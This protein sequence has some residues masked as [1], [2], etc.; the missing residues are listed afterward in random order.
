MTRN[1]SLW[2]AA[3]ISIIILIILPFSFAHDEGLC[4]RHLLNRVGPAQIQRHSVGYFPRICGKQNATS[5]SRQHNC[6][7]QNINLKPCYC[8]KILLLYTEL[9]WLD[10][11]CNIRLCLYFFIFLALLFL[12]PVTKWIFHDVFWIHYCWL[13]LTWG[14]HKSGFGYRPVRCQTPTYQVSWSPVSQTCYS[15]VN[16][17]R[18]CCTYCR[19]D[20]GTWLLHCFLQTKSAQ[21]TINVAIT[22]HKSSQSMLQSQPTNHNQCCNH[23]AQIITITVA[24]TAHKSVLQSQ[25]TNHHNQCCNHSTQ[26][27]INVAITAHKSVLQSQHTNHNQ[28]C[29]HNAQI[30]INVAITTHKQTTHTKRAFGFKSLGR[31]RCFP[32][33]IMA[34]TISLT[35]A[36][37]CETHREE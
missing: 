9:A 31:H 1:D 5:G 12:T 10:W 30:T 36:D 13:D 18:D 29:H 2:P 8:F 6:S 28:C 21:I 24:I 16:P 7:N 34:T 14:Y 17:R 22:A 27:T 32:L 35:Q 26:I 33:M 23:S 19:C 20:P 37:I 11:T 4:N 3:D 15:T 25:H